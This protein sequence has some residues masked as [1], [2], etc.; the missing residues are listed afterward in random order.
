VIVARETDAALEYAVKDL[1]FLDVK[2]YSLDFRLSLGPTEVLAPSVAPEPA[3]DQAK[4]ESS[5]KSRQR[6]SEALLS[7]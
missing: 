1:P 5:G 4:D 6:I 7:G 3:E 2:T